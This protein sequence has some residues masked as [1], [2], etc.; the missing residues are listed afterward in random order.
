M[1]K[2]KENNV[3]MSL[4]QISEGQLLKYTNMMKGWQ[5]RWF[6]LD[7][8]TGMLEYFMSEAERKQRPRASLHL[9]GAIVVPSE[10]DSYTFSVNA[11]NENSFK[12]RATDAKERQH[13]I[14]RLR[15]VAQAHTQVLAESNPPLF[16]DHSQLSNSNLSTSSAISA[17]PHNTGPSQKML[18]CNLTVLDAFSGVRDYLRRVECEH[19]RLVHDI[20]SLP[21]SGSTT[22]CTDTEILILKATSQAT[23]LCLEQCLA[24]LHYQQQ[25][26]TKPVKVNSAGSSPLLG[27]SNSKKSMEF[28]QISD[29]PRL[30]SESAVSAL[31]DKNLSGAYSSDTNESPSVPVLDDE[32]QYVPIAEESLSLVAQEMGNEEYKG[33]TLK[34]LSQLKLGTELTKVNLP[35]FCCEPRSLLQVIADAF[36]QP[37]LL[38]K[39]AKESDADHRMAMVVQWYLGCIRA[40]RLEMT[41]ARKPFNPVLGEIF[42]CIWNM[43]DEDTGEMLVFRFL[44]EQVSHNPPVSAFH[45]ECQQRGLSVHGNLSIKAKFMG[46][47]VGVALGG[48]LV[49][50]L[51]PHKQSPEGDIEKYEMTFPMLYLR[52][53]LS[54]PWLE[55]GGK[56]NVNCSESRSSAGIVFQT[57]PFYGGKPHQVTAEIKTHSGNTAA[58]MSG[59][60]MSGVMEMSW[61]NGQSESINLETV[62]EWLEKKIRRI[63]DQADDESYKLWHPVR[64]NLVSGD[65]QMAA[66]HKKMIEE[67]SRE[68]ERKR[69]NQGM[70][71]CATYFEPNND[72][73]L[74]KK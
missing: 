6:V 11:A 60:W 22:T 52:S 47:Y 45:F 4:R 10:E 21:S 17:S 33:R 70:S 37:H 31:S 58:R 5:N 23:L 59:D 53:F 46:M 16:R 48:D 41:A 8:R 39:M 30:R 67:R 34:L 12:L 29:S 3:G 71:F 27:Y 65:F 38:L 49:L 72:L 1:S 13:W 25:Q 28:K 73:W 14:N 66:E 36:R 18:S 24:I 43:K 56:I 26:P 54:E 68:K 7:P 44:A 64:Q 57:K 61:V 63:S 9:A 19:Q 2:S 35:V 55:F 69:H 40:C 50:Q 51:P 15:V 20:E 32:S 74:R 62:G 42:K